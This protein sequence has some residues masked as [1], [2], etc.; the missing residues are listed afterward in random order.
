MKRA[1]RQCLLTTYTWAI[2]KRLKAEVS[3]LADM[4][5]RTMSNWLTWR[6][7]PYTEALLEQRSV[8]LTDT[9]LE[10]AMMNP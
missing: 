2:P 9:K 3:V 8:L 6:M 7:T 5:H 10:E 1:T 4:D